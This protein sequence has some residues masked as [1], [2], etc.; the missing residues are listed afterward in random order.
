MEGEICYSGRTT[1]GQEMNRRG[2]G[3]FP[4][5]SSNDFLSLYVM[6]FFCDRFIPKWTLTFPFHPQKH[7]AAYTATGASVGIHLFIFNTPLSA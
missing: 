6:L 1:R 7:S 5:P 2:L 4:S 3:F